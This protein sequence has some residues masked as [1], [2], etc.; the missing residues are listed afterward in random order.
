MTKQ[1]LALV[2]HALVAPFFIANDS[3]LSLFSDE[4]DP[5]IPMQVT[6]TTLTP[7]RVATMR[8]VGPYGA[9]VNQ[10]WTGT[11]LPW[12]FAQGLLPGASCFGR[13]LDDPH[14]TAPEQCRYDAMVQVPDD[15]VARSPAS[16]ATLPGGRYAVAPFVGTVPQLTV[17]WTELLRDWLPAS[18]MKLDGRPLIEHMPPDARYDAATGVM[19]CELCI[20][21]QP[22]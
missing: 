7:V 16:M 22:L 20:P 21:V 14:I 2:I 5:V 13:G 17:A 6:L 12:C 1:L 4:L 15:F 10:F 8:H 3:G 18:G 11:F 19:Q 9:S